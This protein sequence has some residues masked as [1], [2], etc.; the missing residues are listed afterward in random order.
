M[1]FLSDLDVEQLLPPPAHLVELARDALVALAAGRADVPAKPAVH[2]GGLSFANA[3]PAAHPERNLLG[4]KWISIFPDNQAKGLPTAAGLMV[5]NDGTTGFPRL[6]ME[7][8][9]LTA[10]RTAAVSGACIAAFGRLDAPTAILGAGVQARSH[11]QVLAALGSPEVTV[12]ARRAEARRALEDWVAQETPAL[13]V[14]AVGSREEALRGAQVVVTALTI[15]LSGAQLEQEWLADDALVLPLDYA[16]SVGPDLAASSVLTADHVPQ[17]E[18]VRA[19][20]SLGTYPAAGRWT[21]DLLQGQ[22]LPH[23]RVVCQN[24]GNG[25]TDLVVAAAVADSAEERGAG[26]LLVTAGT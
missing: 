6:V 5:V 11:L 17:F 16:S 20:G 10:A 4:C 2:P 14:H 24:L 12:Y 3:M 25:L 21:G 15:G 22:P 26:Q 8:A 7:A 1:R 18:A 9:A 19:A 23:G 13:A